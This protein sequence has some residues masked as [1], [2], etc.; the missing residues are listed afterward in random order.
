MTDQRTPSDMQDYY[1]SMLAQ[2]KDVLREPIAHSQESF[3]IVKLLELVAQ[4][5]VAVDDNPT[6]LIVLDTVRELARNT[7]EDVQV[8]RK[9]MGDLE[10]ESLEGFT[11]E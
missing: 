9:T 8:V 10:A 11:N 7:Q 5:T 6:D 1:H 3:V 2:M 4:L